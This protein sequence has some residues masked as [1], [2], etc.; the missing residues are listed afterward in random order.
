[1]ISRGARVVSSALVVVLS[2]WPLGLAMFG[3]S[4]FRESDFWLRGAYVIAS[5]VLLGAAQITMLAI[6]GA[7]LAVLW[8]RR[9]S[10]R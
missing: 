2:L 5:A 4:F 6:G 3:W 10:H 9:H 1:M 8:A 7:C